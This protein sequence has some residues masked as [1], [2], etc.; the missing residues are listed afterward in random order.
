MARETVE[1][2][3]YENGLTANHVMDAKEENAFMTRNLFAQ[4][5]GIR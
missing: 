3:L 5:E 1:T 4:L 2:E